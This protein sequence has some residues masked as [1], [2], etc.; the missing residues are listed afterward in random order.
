MNQNLKPFSEIR[1]EV[2]HCEIIVFGKVENS[3]PACPRFILQKHHR[4][5]AQQLISHLS[6]SLHHYRQIFSPQSLQSFKLAKNWNITGM[7]KNLK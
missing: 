3:S 4:K 5:V 2:I 6:F 7:C 1:N